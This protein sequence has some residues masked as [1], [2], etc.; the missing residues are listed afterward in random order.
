[1]IRRWFTI[2]RK[3][4]EGMTVPSA[5]TAEDQW[6]EI[7]QIAEEFSHASGTQLMLVSRLTNACQRLISIDYGRAEWRERLIADA[8]TWR[9]HAEEG[10]RHA[11]RMIEGLVK[12][13][14]RL[15]EGRIPDWP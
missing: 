5:P 3:L 11:D 14:E 9:L 15:D 7:R 13:V 10:A 2:P 6:Y 1:V 8:V 4:G 12:V